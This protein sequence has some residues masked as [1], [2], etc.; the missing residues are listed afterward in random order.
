MHELVYVPRREDEASAQLKRIL[1]ELFLR[2]ARLLGS[3]AVGEVVSAEE[4]KDVG[5][6]QLGGTIR[7]AR[8]VDEE[9]ERYAGLVAERARVVGIAEADG[10]DVR[11]LRFEFLLV[12]AQLRNV[13]S[14]ED[15][16]VVS[17]ED[18]N[19]RARRPKGA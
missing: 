6:A 1:A 17:Q 11:V 16:T 15:S 5:L 12:F 8:F 7:L 18:D 2:E 10:G 3:F 9:R 4:V 13:L 14:A 19:G